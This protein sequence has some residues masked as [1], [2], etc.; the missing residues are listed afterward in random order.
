MHDDA[1]LNVLRC[2]ANILGTRGACM[3]RLCLYIYYRQ[4]VG[5]AL[6]CSVRCTA[7]LV[8]VVGFSFYPPLPPPPHTFCL[9]VFVLFCCLFVLI[10]VAVLCECEY[11]VCVCVCVCVCERVRSS[12]S[13]CQPSLC[14]ADCHGFL[15]QN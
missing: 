13:V 15:Y 4:M 8:V 10:F 14:S 6:K 5:V 3:N 7:F 11:A 1:G 2:R 12:V 9:F